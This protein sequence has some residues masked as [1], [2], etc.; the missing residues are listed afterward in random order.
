MLVYL[1]QKLV[2][3]KSLA[4]IRIFQT[5]KHLESS[6]SLVL[7]HLRLQPKRQMSLIQLL[8]NAVFSPCVL[9]DQFDDCCL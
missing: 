8:L 7:I 2:W 4:L 9:T 5:G 1:G 6:R 3:L